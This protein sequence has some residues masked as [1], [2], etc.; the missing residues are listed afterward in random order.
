MPY[1]ILSGDLSTVNYTSYRGGLLSFRDYIEDMQWNVLI[2]LHCDWIF[3][4]WL[5]VAVL[6]GQL[7]ADAEL[8]I[9]WQPPAFDLLDR[10]EEAKADREMVRTGSMTWPEMIMRQGRNPEEQLATIA[11]WNSKFDDAKVVL[12]CD[13]RKMTNQGQQQAE[14][15]KI[16]AK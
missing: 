12:D 14:G 1:E 5:E 8:S 3:E 6:A 15:K 4:R 11:A 9:E 2:P 16:E 10:G 13:P 7:P